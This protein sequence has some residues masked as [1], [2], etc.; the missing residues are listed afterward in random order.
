MSEYEARQA[1]GKLLEQFQRKQEYKYG[2]L[3]DSNG[4]VMVPSRP[5]WAY[6]RYRDDLNRLSL[7]RYLLQEQLPD[8]CPVK[9]GK[10][11]PSD[12][13]DQV[14]EVDWT[15]Y[16]WAPTASTVT[17]HGTQVITLND[18][19]EGRVTA[20]ERGLARPLWGRSGRGRA[21]AGA[22]LHGPGN[23][24]PGQHRGRPDGGRDGRTSTER[25]GERTAPGAGGP[26]ERGHGDHGGRHHPV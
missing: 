19:A 6:I 25:A 3:G 2:L 5:G 1:L 21:L 15:M 23:G 9:V 24:L 7:V 13:F 16:A 26:G 14:L 4:T 12:P 10:K 11:Y 22:G 20:T 17:Q 18:L 8:G